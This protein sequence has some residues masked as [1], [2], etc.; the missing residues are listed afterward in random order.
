MWEF[1]QCLEDIGNLSIGIILFLSH[2]IAIGM[3][4][5]D[6]HYQMIIEVEACVEELL[7]GFGTSTLGE[8]YCVRGT[9]FP[10]WC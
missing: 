1:V 8:E 2:L 4:L 10:F 9:W 7:V 5:G 3:K 6:S